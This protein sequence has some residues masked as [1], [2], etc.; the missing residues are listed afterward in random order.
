MNDIDKVIDFIETQLDFY[1]FKDFLEHRTRFKTV[2]R[3]LE[4]RTK[5]LYK[6]YIY[7]RKISSKSKEKIW[8]Y[9]NGDINEKQL[10]D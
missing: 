9:L 8:E 7:S 5:K 2:Y 1:S 6:W 4:F 10:I 3:R